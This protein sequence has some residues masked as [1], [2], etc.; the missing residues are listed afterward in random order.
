[1]SVSTDLESKRFTDEALER[2]DVP[3]CGP[4]FQFRVAR[5]SNLQQAVVAAIV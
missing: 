2:R 5:R 3:G 4:D 1:M